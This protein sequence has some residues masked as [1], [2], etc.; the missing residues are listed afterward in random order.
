[1]SFE[2]KNAL[3]TG[4]SKGIGAAIA[5]E[6][7]RQGANVTVNCHSSKDD[8]EKVAEQ[9]RDLGQ[10]ALVVAADVS[11]QSAVEDMVRQTVEEFGSLDLFVSNAV[12]SDRELMLDA[13]MDGF[14]RTVDVSMWGAF[15]G[16]RASAQ[17]MVKQGNGGAITMISSPHAHIPFPTAMAYN[18]SK[19]AIDQM[20]RTAAIELVKHNVRVN[21]F[22]PGWIDTPGE[23]KF[24]SEE[25]LEQGAKSLPMNRMGSPEEMAKGVCFTLSDDAA[26]MTGST[27]TMD[28]GVGLPWWSKRTEGGQ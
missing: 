16:M 23:R 9:I 13:N 15:Y 17:Q 18:M 12:Y 20:A 25:Q 21:V 8:A 24:F 26:Y 27:M 2:G 4:S 7:A 11:D 5:L 6:L 22:H 28:G 19:A 10:Q 3:I 1:M 14:R